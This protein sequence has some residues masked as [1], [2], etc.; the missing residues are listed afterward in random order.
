MNLHRSTGKADWEK[1]APASR[2]F[3]QRVAAA[4]KGLVTPANFITIIGLG[5][6]VY[7]LVMLLQ[8]HY[9]LGLV[10]LAAGRLLDI[11]DGIVAEATGTKSALGEFF[12]AVADKVGTFL[13][14]IVLIGIGITYWWVMLALILPQVLIPLVVFYRKQKRLPIHPTRPGK[15][16]MAFLWAGIVGLILVKAANGF[17]PLAILTYIVI[18]LS[19]AFGMYA[20]WQYSTGRNQD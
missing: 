14:F 5:V 1:V 20:L 6:V 8:G 11:L 18:A 10:L 12:D 17:L 9:V 19:F 16:S 15:L 4:T 2:A 7:G 13:T 3:F